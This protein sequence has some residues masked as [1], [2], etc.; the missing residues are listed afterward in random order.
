MKRLRYSSVS[1]NAEF[2]DG[3]FPGLD[4]VIEGSLASDRRGLL[5]C[6]GKGCSVVEAENADI[7]KIRALRLAG[8][9]SDATPNWPRGASD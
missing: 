1:P 3:K 2:L 9:I 4:I 5:D 8:N 7:Y 6:V